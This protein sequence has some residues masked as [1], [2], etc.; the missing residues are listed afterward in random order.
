MLGSLAARAQAD[1]RLQRAV[2][3]RD[4]KSRPH[5]DVR[6]RKL[7]MLRLALEVRRPEHNKE[8]IPILLQSWS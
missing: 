3:H 5:K 6:L 8:R 7:D 1:V 4:N 2:S